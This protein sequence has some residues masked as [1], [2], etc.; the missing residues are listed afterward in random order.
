MFPVAFSAEVGMFFGTEDTVKF[1]CESADLYLATTA[2]AG[3]G[4]SM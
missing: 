2:F 3:L 4:S 1:D